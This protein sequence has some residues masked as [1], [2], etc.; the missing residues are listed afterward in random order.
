MTELTFF[1]NNLFARLQYRS[2]F[3][4]ATI[5][6]VIVYASKII[7]IDSLFLYTNGLGGWS[8]NEVY[9]IL[10]LSIVIWL[11]TGM[12]D[13][14][15][16]SY[17]RHVHAGKIDPFLVKPTSQI[18]TLFLRWCDPSKIII[19][20]AIL[21]FSLLFSD[22]VAGQALGHW[23]VFFVLTLCAVFAN[24][25]FIASL[26]LFVFIVHRY[27]PVDF[28]V[29]ELNRLT[30]IP[31][32]LYPRRGLEVL[33]VLLPTIFCASIPAAFMVKGN[34]DIGL[35]FIVFVLVYAVVF[36]FLFVRLINKFDGLGG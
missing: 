31:V 2:N 12:L 29:S 21:P 35:F 22:V 23:A 4:G 17:F 20:G 24:V 26:N 13:S 1:I 34:L 33:I 3:I 5:L 14:S 9:F 32:S 36:R 28:I 30:H 11:I 18:S 7:F 16:Y 10:Y 8:K 6:L 19:L 15:I 27:L 25:L